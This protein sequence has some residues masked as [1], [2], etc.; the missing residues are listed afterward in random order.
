LFEKKVFKY[1]VVLDLRR[2][3]DDSAPANARGSL[4]NPTYVF[5]NLKKSS[6]ECRKAERS[7]QSL[8]LLFYLFTYTL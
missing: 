4:E 2:L 8:L 3:F 5:P 1:T 7:V 6:N